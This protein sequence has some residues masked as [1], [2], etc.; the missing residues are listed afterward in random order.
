MYIYFSAFKKYIDFEFAYFELTKNERVKSFGLRLSKG[1]D[2]ITIF[3]DYYE[4]I[5]LM[6]P[7][8]I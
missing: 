2:I 6:R 5:P 4:W 3:G 8:L 1:N 7:Y